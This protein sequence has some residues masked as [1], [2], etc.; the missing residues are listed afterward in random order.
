MKSG[1]QFCGS[2]AKCQWITHASR[3]RPE[4]PSEQQCAQ[5]A[6][7]LTVGRRSCDWKNSSTP[8]PGAGQAVIRI[9]A[10]SVNFLDV[11]KRRGELVGQ[12]F[13]RRTGRRNLIFLRL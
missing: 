7:T 12:A 5:F 13:Y 8:V 3:M 1:R 4:Q 6:F 10:A 9:H 11:Q 2:S